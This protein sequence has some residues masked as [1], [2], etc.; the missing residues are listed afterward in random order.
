M[1][2]I[3]FL[4]WDELLAIHKDHLQRYGGQDGFIDEGAV[5]AA[6]ARAQFSAGYNTDA[7]LADL[8]ADYMFGLSTTQGFLTAIKERH[9]RARQYFSAETVGNWR[10]PANSCTCW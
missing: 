2:K 7:D 5:H 3:V 8:A 4:T 9:W 6:L 10:C 1:D